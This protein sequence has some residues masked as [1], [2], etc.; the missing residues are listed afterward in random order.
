MRQDGAA[1]LAG[2]DIIG[3]Q[4]FLCNPV[5]RLGRRARGSNNNL[6]ALCVFCALVLPRSFLSQAGLQ[7]A[8]APKVV[9]GSRVKLGT[10]DRRL[11]HLPYRGGASRSGSNGSTGGQATARAEVAQEAVESN[12][13]VTDHNCKLRNEARLASAHGGLIIPLMFK[14]LQPVEVLADNTDKKSPNSDHLQTR[15]AAVTEARGDSSNSLS[16][17]TS[18]PTTFEDR[19]LSQMD[20][21][22]VGNGLQGQ[23]NTVRGLS[24][25][26][27]CLAISNIGSNEQ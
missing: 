27:L 14:A 8:M 7:A 10:Q 20:D 23:S 2:S 6:V 5:I 26:S 9:R 17:V 19:V 22:N 15:V 16:M 12:H 24:L 4:I 3:C 18:V 1:A 11:S 13:T 25:D 21:T